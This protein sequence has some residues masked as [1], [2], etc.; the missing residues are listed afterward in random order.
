M[1]N[2]EED[3]NEEG[4]FYHMEKLRRYQLNRLKLVCQYTPKYCGKQVHTF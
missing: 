1:G 2:K 3:E 4:K